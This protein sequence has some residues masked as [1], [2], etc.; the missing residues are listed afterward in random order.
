MAASSMASRSEF[1]SFC[2][3]RYGSDDDDGECRKS[4]TVTARKGEKIVAVLKGSEAYDARFRH[5]VRQRGFKLVSY[6]ALGLC[7]VLCLPAKTPVS[8][9]NSR[10]TVIPGKFIVQ[11]END[12]TFMSK[13]RRVAFVEDF[14]DILTEI[15]CQ[16]KG[17]IGEKKTVVE[18]S[19]FL[20]FVTV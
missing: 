20:K 9:R 16:E 11:N 3:K 2:R 5:W 15:H 7:D 13:W 6:S 1:T 19:L 14:Y 12:P 10:Y 8:N 17:H 4:K 18:V